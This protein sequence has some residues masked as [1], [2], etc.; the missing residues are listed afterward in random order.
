V[1]VTVTQYITKGVR[2]LTSKIRDEIDVELSVT[3]LTCILGLLGDFV[4]KKKKKI[5]K[6]TYRTAPVTKGIDLG[7]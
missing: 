4:I 1:T 3:T 5:R 2:E 7:T 6:N